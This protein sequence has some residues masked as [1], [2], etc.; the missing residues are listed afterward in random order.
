MLKYLSHHHHH[1]HHQSMSTAQILMNL[2]HAIHLYQ[3]LHLVN[4]LDSTQYPYK[5]DESKLLLVIQH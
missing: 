1:H 5:I 4:L 3:P 2:S